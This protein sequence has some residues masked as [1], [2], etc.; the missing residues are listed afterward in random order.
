[1]SNRR[2][3]PAAAL[4]LAA[5]MSAGA[6]L[7]EFV[8]AQDKTKD[9]KSDAAQ[10]L[11][12]RLQGVWLFTDYVD[13]GRKGPDDERAVMR[14]EFHRN[15]LTLITR[16]APKDNPIR[17]S[18]TLDV[19]NKPARIDITL[20]LEDGNKTYPGIMALEGDTLTLCHAATADGDRPS[21]MEATAKT[22]L[23]TLQR[24]KR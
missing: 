21:T 1:M 23:A 14:L 17:G 7:P 18:W 2:A 20:M 8:V 10:G 3:L 19:E 11:S 22:V 5:L 9:A 15:K 24:Q 12:T 4:A 6:C 13:C 16:R